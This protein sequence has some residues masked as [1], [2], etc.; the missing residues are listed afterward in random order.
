MD[1]GRTRT[2]SID[3]NQLFAGLC[4]IGFINGNLFRVVKQFRDN[5]FA[6]VLMNSLEISVIVWAAL[7]VGIA[8]LR[9]PPAVTM[10][11]FDVALA[12]GAG[13]AFFIPLAPLSWVAISALALRVI[14][15]SRPESYHCR[16]AWILLAMTVPMFWSRV[17]FSLLSDQILAFD[18][19]LVARI[20]GT[21]RAGNAVAFSDG[22]GYLWIAPACSSLANVSLVIPCWVLIT[23]FLNRRRSPGDAW[24]ILAACAAV[25]A[26]NVTR[27]S[28]LSHY[29][30]A[31]DLLHGP[32]GATVANWLTFVAIIGVCALGVRHDV[33][34]F[35]RHF[36]CGP[37][38][39]E[40][41]PQDSR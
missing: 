14:L 26:I 16:G 8:L 17:L 12:V 32:V 3:R 41:P 40:S 34:A 2:T 33:T 38:G 30:Q 5:E 13:V 10:T 37:A 39:L 31:F 36:I 24:W 11:R 20:S 6:S 4:I 7:F 1:R 22:S 35:W 25:T 23:R 18:A 27:L 15:S 28:L 19:I 9:Q 29:S 21:E